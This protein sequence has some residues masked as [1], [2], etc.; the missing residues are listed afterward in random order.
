M[1][2]TAAARICSALRMPRDASGPVHFSWHFCALFVNYKG[3]GYWTKRPSW[4][5]RPRRGQR[6]AQRSGAGAAAHAR[7]RAPSHRAT[8]VAHSSLAEGG[9]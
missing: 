1:L 2:G 7:V 6:T 4:L 3:A 9:V 8:A 5:A